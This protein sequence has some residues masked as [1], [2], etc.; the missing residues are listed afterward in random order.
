MG[1][2]PKASSSWLMN[3]YPSWTTYLLTILGYTAGGF[4]RMI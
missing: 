4:R 1:F 2:P 3:L